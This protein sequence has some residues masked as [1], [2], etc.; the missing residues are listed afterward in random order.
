MAI[1]HTYYQLQC[2]PNHITVYNE[3]MSCY[4][5]NWLLIGIPS[6]KGSL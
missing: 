4:L 3:N 1:L 6:M 5:Y 2:S